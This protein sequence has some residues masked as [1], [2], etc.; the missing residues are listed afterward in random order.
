MS[1]TRKSEKN[2]K[3]G[4][5]KALTQ[6]LHTKNS[7]RTTNFSLKTSSE[8]TKTGLINTEKEIFQPTSRFVEI[9]SKVSKAANITLRTND[10]QK[11]LV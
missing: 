5:Q 10:L 2:T 3:G 7:S 9:A 8:L 1:S 11:K 6:L 4:T